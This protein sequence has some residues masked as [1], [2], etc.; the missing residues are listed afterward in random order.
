MIKKIH[1]ILF[2]GLI[3]IMG[4]KTLVWNLRYDPTSDYA[5]YPDPEPPWFQFVYLSQGE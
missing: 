2:S 3:I 4:Q 5:D 1:K